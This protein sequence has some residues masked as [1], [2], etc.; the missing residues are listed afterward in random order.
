MGYLVTIVHGNGYYC[1]CCGT[2]YEN[3]HRQDELEYALSHLPT[4]VRLTED[5]PIEDEHGEDA[6][7]LS[8]DDPFD[9]HDLRKVEIEDAATGDAVAW[10]RMSSTPHDRRVAGPSYH[11]WS[12][13]GRD[14]LF[15]VIWASGNERITDRSWDQLY[16][17][18]E[19]HQAEAVLSMKERELERKQGEVSAA[20]GHLETVKA[21][22]VG[23]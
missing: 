4:I 9:L 1:S 22:V 5:D 19:V 15:E 12:G 21:K 8:G 23:S 3:T 6:M 14:G 18:V 17:E 11:R 13:W 16:H 7:D 20:K 10:G 2:T